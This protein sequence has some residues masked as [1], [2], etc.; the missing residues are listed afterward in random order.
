MM[1]QIV[2]TDLILVS[3]NG[4][5]T[6]RIQTGVQRGDVAVLEEDRRLADGAAA[7]QEAFLYQLLKEHDRIV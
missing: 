2:L 1:F 3:A 6:Q 5:D 4:S 7:E